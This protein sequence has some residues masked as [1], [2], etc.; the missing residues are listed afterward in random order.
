M[1]Y[2]LITL[3]LKQHYTDMEKFKT[4]LKQLE[5]HIPAFAQQ[6]IAVS[7]AS[8]GWHI[9]HTLLTCTLI[10]GAVKQSDPSLY[11]RSFNF[12]KIMVY[13]LNKIPRGRAKAPKIVLPS[14]DINPE[15]LQIHFQNT[16]QKILV[17]KNLPAGHYFEHPYFGKLNVKETVRFLE[18]HSNH[19]LK[20]IED[21][22]Q[23]KVG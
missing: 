19:H 7:S 11:K 23:N 17:L 22:L 5:K 6:N 16:L 13:T 8:V 9:E 1:P 2:K 15:N 21:I 4:L 10:A 18:I 12:S 14:A 20:I 3:L